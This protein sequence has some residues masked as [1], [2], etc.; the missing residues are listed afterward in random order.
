M[1][2]AVS[3]ARTANT[4]HAHRAGL[5]PA[6]TLAGLPRWPL[7]ANMALAIA[8]ANTVP[9]RC[10]MKLI[11]DALP[12]SSGATALRTAVGTVGSA[13]EMPMPA[14]SSAMSSSTQLV[15]SE[16]R[17]ATQINPIACSA[18]PV[19]MIGRRPI[20]SDRAPASGE[21]NIGVAKN[22][23]RRSPVPSGE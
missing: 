21:T 14:I 20:R 6:V 1:A 16:P 4:A 8:I 11:P 3:A 7:P 10:A 18:R 23:S 12:I 13:M 19:T 22:G 17:A 2:S 5:K 9:K 15:A